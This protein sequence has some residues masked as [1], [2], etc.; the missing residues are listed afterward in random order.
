MFTMVDS[1]KLLQGLQQQMVAMRSVYIVQQ[2]LFGSGRGNVELLNRSGSNVFAYFESLSDQYIISK[3]SAMT[4]KRV[5][6]GR[7]TL[8]TKRLQYMLNHIPDNQHLLTSEFLKKFDNLAADLEGKLSSIRKFRH[9]H[10]AH[11]DLEQEQAK[12]WVP[13]TR[14]QIGEAME[15]MYKLLNHVEYTIMGGCITNYSRMRLPSGSDGNELL[16][17]LRMIDEAQP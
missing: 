10:V 15:A 2:Q 7:E 14:G 4:D 1:V 11:L 9:K 13:L 3:L 5:V 6:A 12:E 16:R 8:S 17:R